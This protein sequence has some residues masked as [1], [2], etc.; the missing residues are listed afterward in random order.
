MIVTIDNCQLEIDTDRG[1]IYVHHPEGFTAVRICG[2]KPNI[3]N[4][5][6]EK[7]LDITLKNQSLKPYTFNW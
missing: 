2:V 1:V 7:M 4:P 6:M 5:S 3:P